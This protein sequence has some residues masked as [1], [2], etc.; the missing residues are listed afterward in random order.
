[1]SVPSGNVACV[2]LTEQQGDDDSTLWKIHD[3][4]VVDD[5]RRMR[6]SIA[7]VE[8]PD[9]VEFEQYVFRMPRAAMTVALDDQDHVLMIWRHRFIMDR[10]TWELPGGYVDPGEQ[11]A[12]TAA[13]ELREE[14]GY[15]ASSVRP[16]ATFQP[17]AG[18]A[19]FENHV[20]L[21]EGLMRSG[22]QVDINESARIEWVP[23]ARIPELLAQGEIIGAGT[24]IGLLHAAR[25][26]GI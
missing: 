13:R 21:A 3:E 8:L 24:Q 5:T 2:D 16:L 19:D 10:W 7:H 18:S 6:V 4:R 14:A 11:P 1:M 20:F 15:I 23:L 9:G 25:L 22:G 17:L 26:R 12:Q